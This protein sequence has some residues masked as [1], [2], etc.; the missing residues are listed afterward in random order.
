M[1]Y[2][3]KVEVYRH[4]PYGGLMLTIALLIGVPASILLLQK[5]DRLPVDVQTVRPSV[6]PSLPPITQPVTPPLVQTPQQEPIFQAVYKKVF[7]RSLALKQSQKLKAMLST[8]IW[9]GRSSLTR[10]N[11]KKWNW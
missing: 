10:L 6:V 8:I 9:I 5:I 2:K 1:T 4:T 11:F 3:F 7:T